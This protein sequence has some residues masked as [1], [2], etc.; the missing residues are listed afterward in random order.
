MKKIN[1]THCIGNRAKVKVE[2]FK[3]KSQ[4]HLGT[5]VYVVYFRDWDQF[6]RFWSHNNYMDAEKFYVKV[7]R[8]WVETENV[9]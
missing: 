4:T 2:S 5:S 7:G 9:K 6:K 1:N 8:S 3:Y